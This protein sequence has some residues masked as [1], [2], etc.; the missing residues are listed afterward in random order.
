MVFKSKQSDY[1]VVVVD[2]KGM[3]DVFEWHGE[4][5]LERLERW[6]DNYSRTFDGGCPNEETA[7][8]RGYDPEPVRAMI[9]HIPTGKILT[10]WYA[11]DY[12][13]EIECEC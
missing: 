6:I 4:A 10:Q 1:A 8:Y 11:P 3:M 9:A 12:V 7:I 13:A 2:E 5:T